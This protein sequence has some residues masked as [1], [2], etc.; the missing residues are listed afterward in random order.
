MLQSLLIESF[1]GLGWDLKTF[2]D[3]LLEYY[4]VA[5]IFTKDLRGEN[6]TAIEI[7]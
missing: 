6:E 3:V 4:L 1:Q 5:K 2:S 7:T